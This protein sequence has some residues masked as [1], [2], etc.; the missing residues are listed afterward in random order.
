MSPV[1]AAL[2]A[3]VAA[4][5]PKEYCCHLTYT[6]TVAR[7]LQAQYGGDLEII[8]LAAIAHDFGRVPEGDNSMHAELGAPKVEAFL[9]REGYPAERAVRVARCVFMHN[10]NEGFET[11]EEEVVMNA[12]RIS[13]VIH[14]EAFILL[15]KKQTVPDRARWALKYLDKGM[16]V[17]LPGLKEKYEALYQQ[18][19]AVY[20][21]VLEKANRTGLEG[22]TLSGAR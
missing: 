19:R 8:E 7:E 1:F 9:I 12:D 16:M 14:H 18:K 4:Y 13:K 10:K 21:A 2:E 11:I 3:A 6:L 15:S 20:D 17:T 22:E 5:M